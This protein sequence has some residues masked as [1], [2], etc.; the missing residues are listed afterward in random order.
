MFKDRIKRIEIFLLFVFQFFTLPV[1][2]NEQANLHCIEEVRLCQD[3]EFMRTVIIEKGQPDSLYENYQVLNYNFNFISISYRKSGE[4]GKL[5]QITVFDENAQIFYWI[6]KTNSSCSLEIKDF[7]EV[8]GKQILAKAIKHYCSL[9]I[10][11]KSSSH[12]AQMRLE[13]K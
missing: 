6:L 9:I 5:E 2:A 8:V 13:R 3:F 1:H 4:Q 12:D 10:E 11:L 7:T